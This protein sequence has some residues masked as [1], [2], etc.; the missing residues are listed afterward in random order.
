MKGMRGI[1]AVGAALA[2]VGLAPA[3]AS[4]S[5]VIGEVWGSSGGIGCTLSGGTYSQSAPTGNEYKAPYDGV[6]TSWTNSGTFFGLKL[7]VTRLG[8]ASS[9]TV[10]ASSDL[11][12]EGTYPVRIPIRQGDVL[13]ASVSA[14]SFSECAGYTD[15][16]ALR[17]AGDLAP[18]TTVSGTPEN[19]LLPIEAV[20]ERD[21]DND[22]YG[23]ETQDQC[24][25]SATTQGPCPL[26]T[27]LGQTFAP[28]PSG[29]A[30]ADYVVVNQIGFPTAAQQDGVITGWQYAAGS[31]SGAGAIRLK[32]FRPLGLNDYRVVG[33]DQPRTPASNVL[34]S[35][36]VRIPVRQGD[37]IGIHTTGP[38][39][40]SNASDANNR[41]AVLAGDLATG[42]SA[43]FT[44]S[45]GTGRRMNVAATLE[46]DADGDGFGDTSQDKCPTNP[47]TQGTCPPPSP[48]PPSPPP[49]PSA[50]CL[51][52][53]EG[54]DDAKQKLKKAK[55][56]LAMAEG[57]KR[58]KKAR[59]KVK[60]AKAKVKKANA[61]V[62][63]AC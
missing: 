17:A 27:V 54:L 59:K 42:S 12:G 53:R 18:G 3:Q 47:N 22:G 31:Y 9:F 62:A 19:V 20:I 57:K 49:Q 34:N 5:D 44:P 61:A 36:P 30:T 33:A 7:K 43:T 14:N 4:A 48:P 55:S 46:A 10:V 60:K 45:G 8:A 26:P 63:E 29:G 38:P 37:R 50:E 6:L 56:K 52:A 28:A 21:V 58:K 41:Y 25:S 15:S 23:D 13:G 40:A 32:M 16:T 35:W 24:P 1:V 2:C 39:V 51:K 11:R